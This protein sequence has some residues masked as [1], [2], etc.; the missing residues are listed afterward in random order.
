M[1][2]VLR[3]GG[4]LVLGLTLMPQIAAAGWY[5]PRGYGGYGWGGWGM[6]PA[7]VD[8][9]AGYMAGLGAFARGQGVYEVEDAKARAINLQTMTQW[10][11]QLRAR[12]KEL[13]EQ[14][15]QEEA[16]R[17]A[18]RDAR[19][20]QRELID[21]TTLNNLLMQI[22]DFDPTAMRSTQARAPIGAS[23]VREIPFEW[24]T[25]AITICLDQLTA[26]DALPEALNDPAFRS[27]RDALSKAVDAALAEDAKSDVTPATMKR[28]TSAVAA[29]RAR[30]VQ[31]VPRDDPDHDDGADYFAT[32]ASLARL[33]HD[34]SMKKVLAEL[35]SERD[36]TVGKLIGFMQ[37][38]NLRFGPA[39]TARQLQI[40][41]TL[42]GL[43]KQVTSDLSTAPATAPEP[44]PA[45]I[46]PPPAPGV[47]GGNGKPLQNAA[48]Q[49]FGKMDWPQLEAHAR[50]P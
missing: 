31:R 27:E 3:I 20:E 41:Q 50:E 15:Q 49:A 34:P 45:A 29:F 28:L 36:T 48:K 18:E 35:E 24:N 1:R 16:Q 38:Y 42:V 47:A 44:A 13:Q 4:I 19:V 12:Q 9:A 2:Y 21:G 22:L 14:K 39:T 43:L 7:P 8:P 26:R 37:A 33:L 23:A 17:R 10:N 6:G 5:Y 40:Y 32:M 46:P 30:F 11:Q 25:E